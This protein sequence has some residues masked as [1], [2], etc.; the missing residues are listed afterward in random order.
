[1]SLPFQCAMFSFYVPV[2]Q[3]TRYQQCKVQ[4]PHDMISWPTSMKGWSDP[5]PSQ[6][7]NS[8]KST[9]A[10]PS[11]TTKNHPASSWDPGHWLHTKRATNVLTAVVVASGCSEHHEHHSPVKVAMLQRAIP[12]ISWVKRS[13]RICSTLD[14]LKAVFSL[15]WY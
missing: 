2:L 5:S 1:M 7:D 15:Q 14:H 3:G 13:P 8:L 9:G 6:T 11:K 12:E 10:N 4:L